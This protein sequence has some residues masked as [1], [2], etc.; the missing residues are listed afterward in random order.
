MFKIMFH[1]GKSFTRVVFI[2]FSVFGSLLNAQNSNRYFKS[3]ELVANH[4]QVTVSDGSILFTPYSKSTMEI[5]FIATGKTNPEGNA[6]GTH[7]Q[8]VKTTLNNTDHY[9]EYATDGLVVKIEK[10][11]FKIS[12]EYLN[13]PLFSEEQGYFQNDSLLGFRMQLTDSEKLMGGGERVLRMDRRG[14]RLQLY[15]KASYGYET[16]AELMYYSMPVVISSNKY[17]LVFDNG[18]SGYLDLGATEKN[19]L[20]FEAVGGRSSYLL[21][22][23]DKWT[24]LT[25]NYTSFTGLQPM[26]PRWALGNIASRFGYH[27]QQQV[28]TVVEEYKKQ[29][30]PLDAIVLD[31]YWFGA[32]IKGTMG[33]LEWHTDS[34]PNP[35]KMM[36]DLKAQGVKTVLITEPFILKQSGKFEET[37]NL[38]L[39]G[40]RADGSP[41]LY[42]FYFGNTALLD[43]FKPETQT[44]FWN[45]YKKHTLSG[46][47]GWW[48]DLGEPE[49][50]P[51][52]LLHVNG[53]ANEVHN[54]YG[55]EW[56]KMVYKGFAHDFENKRPVILMRA[57]FAGSQRYGLVPWSGD[58]N[59]SWGGLSSQVE[60]A[61]QMSLQGLAYMHSDLGGFAGDYKDS[62]LYTRWLQYGVFQPIYRPHAQEEVPSEP[63]YWDEDTKNIVRRYI[64]LRYSLLPYNYTLAYQN[65]TTGLPLMRP[66]FYVDTKEDLLNEKNLYLWG[67]NFLVA[68]VIKKDAKTQHVYFPKESVWINFW[69][70]ETFEGGQEVDVPVDIQNIPVY[71]KAGSFIPMVKPVQSTDFYSSENVTLHY[72]FHASVENSEGM[73]YDDDGKSKDAIAKNKYE[74]IH[75]KSENDNT[76]LKLSITPEGFAYQGKP[77]SRTFQTAIHNLSEKPTATFINGKKVHISNKQKCLFRTKTPAFWDAAT[78]QLILM[79]TLQGN[80]LHIK[81]IL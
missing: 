2:L 56:A 28:H 54:L 27:S 18:A 14:K 73:M 4:L 17:M 13:K 77:Q 66:L 71:V 74:I 57:G 70:G 29:N 36:M 3:A 67:D 35:E 62:E 78:K 21:I 8:L 40:T 38:N 30:I 20:Q 75:F 1:S 10:S 50:H 44:W 11:P 63:I 76:V 68:P 16:Q 47:E 12:Y 49:V 9:V 51:D 24:D 31:L 45:I 61:L 5:E 81:I 32:D 80:P 19:I 41:Y 6:I 7:A 69:T 39:L 42:D 58:V 64:Q 34:F 33:N 60:I 59:R 48:G 79:H 25:T 37:K 65:A 26:I 53:R 15:N 72:Y 23:A 55:H 22:A 46:V 52:D 43:I